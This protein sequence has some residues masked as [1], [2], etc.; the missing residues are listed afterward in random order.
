MRRPPPLLD[1]AEE[2]EGGI[3][4]SSSFPDDA[5]AEFEGPVDPEVFKPARI[6]TTSASS[7]V[8]DVFA[9][10]IAVF[11]VATT[12]SFVGGRLDVIL[13]INFAIQL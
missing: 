8:S 4:S 7:R 12:V 6:A 5:E 9:S 1:E 2:F 11:T 13:F 10:V 3:S